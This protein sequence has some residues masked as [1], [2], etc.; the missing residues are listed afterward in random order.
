[1]II[2]FEGILDLLN[3][4]YPGAM[5]SVLSKNIQRNLIF[6]IVEMCNTRHNE[7]DGCYST[8]ENSSLIQEQMHDTFQYITHNLYSD[9]QLISSNKKEKSSYEK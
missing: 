3:S 7:C 4:Y 8:N 6:L 5:I 9:C 1:M 2:K